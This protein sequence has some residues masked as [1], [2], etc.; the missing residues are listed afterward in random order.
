MFTPNR[1]SQIALSCTVATLASAVLLSSI[2]SAQ[3]GPPQPQPKP[4]RDTGVTKVIT[5]LL[6]PDKKGD[7]EDE[8]AVQGPQPAQKMPG[9]PGGPG[10]MPPNFQLPPSLQ[11][12]HEPLLTQPPLTNAKIE[13]PQMDE[14]NPPV[15][16]H[17]KLDDPA[18][19]LG[20]TSAGTKLK[21]AIV[22]NDAN[23]FQEAKPGL[24]QLRQ[25]LID[26]TEAH[27]GLYKALNQI[28]S[29]RGQAE[30]EKEL[31]LQFAQLR[32]RSMMEMARVYIAEK[33]YGKAVKELTEVIKSQPKSRVGLRSYEMLQEIGFTE[34]LQLAQ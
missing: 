6:H 24:F 8:E 21:R 2:A 22:L 5:K 10:G 33:D 12:G 28:P 14:E 30:L 26:L 25:S 19:P 9:A 1:F 32:D 20:F 18:N 15:L 7:A 13:T 23:R 34:K 11:G 17:P 4:V 27:I 29:A 16:S 3:V 31:A